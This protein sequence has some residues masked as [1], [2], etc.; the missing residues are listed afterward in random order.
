MVS[1]TGAAALHVNLGHKLGL[2]MLGHLGS[3]MNGQVVLALH[4]EDFYLFLIADQHTAVAHLATHL[5]IEGRMVEHQLIV[6]LVFLLNAAVLQYAAGVL[7]LVQVVSLRLTLSQHHPVGGI[8]LGSIA[9]AFL[10]LLHLAVKSLGVNTQPLLVANK[11]RQVEREAKRVKQR[12]GLHA[13]NNR[14]TL[15]LSLAYHAVKQVDARSQSAEESL[16]LLLHNLGDEHL[17]A[18]QLGVGLTHLTD[19]R[20]QQLIHKSLLL[21]EERVAVPHGAP[22]DA[23][24]HIA[25]LGIARQLAVG[26][27]ESY[28]PHMVGYHAHGH[29]LLLIPAILGAAKVADGLDQGLEYVSVVVAALAL[30]RH[31]QTL[32]A[33]AGVNHLGRQRLQ[34]AIGL[35]VILHKDQVPYLYHLRIILVDQLSTGHLGLLLIRAQVNMNLRAGAAGTRIAHLPEVV[36]L[37]AV[38]NMVLGQILLPVAGGLIVTLQALLGRALKHRGVERALVNLEHINQIFPRPADGLL[39]KIVAEAPVAQHLKHR[40][41]IGIVTHLLQVVMLAAHAQAL[42][43]VSHTATL[44]LSITQNDILKLVHARI[45]KHQRRVILYYHRCRGHHQVAALLKKPLKRISD[46]FSSHHFCIFYFYLA[47][48]LRRNNYICTLKHK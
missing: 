33:H 48:K 26:N 1:L 25:G 18:L 32:K 41:V 34:R 30:Q 13:V 28:S 31:T 47:A 5:G 40:V 2:R 43:R 14:L 42:L 27:R 35:A 46:F 20:R 36:M 19:K 39:L 12:K 11:L 29:I 10:L 45:G 44:R 4:I 17:L 23:P 9:G 22:Q 8:H 37:I 7:C 16:F 24:Y 3:E 38:D 6:H 21:A 15:L